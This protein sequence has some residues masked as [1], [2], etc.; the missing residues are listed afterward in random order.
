VK[1]LPRWPLYLIAAPAAVAVWPG[2][3]GLGT[4]CGFGLVHPLPGI[5]NGFTI[6]TSITLPVGVEA[7]GSY[8]VA[9]WLTPGVPASAR[10]FAKWSAI[11]ALSLGMLGQVAYHLLSAAHAARAP[12]PVVVLVSSLPVIVLGFGAALSHLLRGAEDGEPA[13]A[14]EG[15]PE[16]APR[17][18]PKT[19]PRS[20][21]RVK[22]KPAVKQA[23]AK[24]VDPADLYAAGLAAGGVPSLRR[25]RA[26][27]HV[28]QDRAKVIQTELSALLMERVA[29]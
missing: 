25:I 29:V 6:D 1:A 9:A 4:L 8:A 17:S 2:W 24:G 5:D 27:M 21:P 22:A 18:A 15:V 3:V 10:R 23:K 12:W 20:R 19:A 16:S 28:L 26:D 11:G 14:P 13:S 7:Y